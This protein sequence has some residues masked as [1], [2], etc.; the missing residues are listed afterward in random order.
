M[1]NSLLRDVREFVRMET[2]NDSYFILRIFF[3]FQTKLWVNINWWQFSNLW[4]FQLEQPWPCLIGCYNCTHIH[5]SYTCGLSESERKRNE[6]LLLLSYW[7]WC[8][9]RITKLIRN[10]A[11]SCVS[12]SAYRTMK[13]YFFCFTLA[14]GALSLSFSL[15]VL[16]AL[17]ISLSSFGTHFGQH[18]Y[19]PK[20][21]A[22]KYDYIF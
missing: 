17:P 13:S 10:N 14:D 15:C 4:V 12:K 2:G 9:W 20:R 8:K 18:R 11:S 6:I 16:S 3:S 21:K 5:T 1:L 7:N 22:A 19:A